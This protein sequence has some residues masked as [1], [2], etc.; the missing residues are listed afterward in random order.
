MKGIAARLA[1]DY[2]ESNKGW[3]ATIDRYKDR[4]IDEHLRRSLWVLFAAVETVMFNACVNLA[5]LLPVRGAARD[6]LGGST[7]KA[8][9]SC[10]KLM[11]QASR[12]R[13]R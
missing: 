8:K 13:S 2:P 10:A 11:R 7:E 5:N 3:I 6:A 12:Q 1:H 9:F 4:F